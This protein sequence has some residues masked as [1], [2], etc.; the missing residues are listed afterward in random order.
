M[1]GEH[2]VELFQP[3]WVDLFDSPSNLLM[4]LLSPFKKQAVISYLLGEGVFKDIFELREKSLLVDE[5]KTLKVDEMG[6]KLF[7]HFH[8]GLKDTKGKFSPNHRS[9]MHDSLQAFIQAVDTGGNDIQADLSP[10]GKKIIFVSD[11]EGQFNI[12]EYSLEKKQQKRLTD[13]QS[14]FFNPCW[15]PDSVM[16]AYSEY[17]DQSY[18]IRVK[19][20]KIGRASC[21][22][23]V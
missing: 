9:Y 23:R 2:L 21:R 6:F 4:D 3:V 11:F 10:D 22:E 19:S 8:D 12:Y 14:G 15:F 5:L 16:F 18:E 7:F 13:L 1:V 17:H 20:S